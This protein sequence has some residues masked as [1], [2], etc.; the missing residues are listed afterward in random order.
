VISRRKECKYIIDHWGFDVQSN[1]VNHHQQ[2]QQE[3]REKAVVG[4][5][6]GWKHG[7]ADW[8]AAVSPI[9]QCFEWVTVLSVAVRQAMQAALEGSVI[10]GQE[11][12]QCGS[13]VQ[14]I[15][16][17]G[18]AQDRLLIVLNSWVYNVEAQQDF[19]KFV[20]KY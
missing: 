12:F 1:A 18:R 20:M 15:N 13:M 7:A 3:E 16:Q 17:D 10:A 9:D 6:F 19:S 11:I 2:T 4:Y 14:K 8:R 5:G